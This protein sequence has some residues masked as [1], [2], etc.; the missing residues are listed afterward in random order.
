[1]SGSSFDLTRTSIWK[2][3]R[4]GNSDIVPKGFAGGGKAAKSLETVAVGG[5]RSWRFEESRLTVSV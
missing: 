5:S 3:Q 4:Q 1:M 2:E